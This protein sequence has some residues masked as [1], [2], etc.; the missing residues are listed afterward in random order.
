M[1]RALISGVTGFVGSHLAEHL[2]K[3]GYKVFGLKRWRSDKQNI[4]HIKELNLIEGDITDICS[5]EKSLKETKPDYIFH[6]ASQSFM[7]MS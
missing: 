6:L 2:I 1:R 4:S 7:P 5:L 3:D